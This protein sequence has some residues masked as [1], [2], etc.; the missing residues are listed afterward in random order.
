MNNPSLVGRIEEKKILENALQSSKPEMV[1][2]IGRR[3]IGKT[4]LVKSVYGDRIDYEITGIQHASRQEQLRNFMMQIAKYSLGHFPITQPKDWLEAFY[5]L[6]KFLEG[7][8]KAEKQIIFLDELPWLETP[9]S[10]FLKGLGWFW[11][12]WAVNQNIVVVI[13]GSAASWMI[14]KVVH[15]KGGLHNRITKRIYLQPFDLEETEHFFKTKN[16][17]FDRYQILQLYM[18]LGGVPHYLEEVEGGKSTAQNIDA[19]CFS[20]NGL[21]WDEFPKL[22][23]S[24]FDNSENH[25]K[26]IRALASKHKGL[27]RSEIVQTTALPEGGGFSTV[28]EELLHS[29][30]I[31]VYLPFGKKKKDSLYRLTDEFSLFYFQFMEH[32]LPGAANIWQQ[33]SKTQTYIS[34]A[35][36]AFENI[37]FKHIPQIKKALG[38]SGVYA[39][40]Y[41][42]LKKGNE[43]EEGIQLDLLI[44][45]NDHVINLCEIK[46]YA[47]EYT[48]DKAAAMKYRNRIAKFKE[49]SHTRKQV[50][51]T[52]I[53]TFGIKENPYSLG[54][55]DSA[56]TMDD[57]F[58]KR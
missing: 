3:R 40:V 18:A 47:A 49:T 9:K 11:N 12:S 30:F 14:K 27:T 57:L 34:W 15:D 4:F 26:V 48:I 1:A 20:Q 10:G 8:Q 13:C 44:D 35:G 22:Y 19:I 38:I 56:L 36:Y 16:L 24:L 31:S 42:Y 21:L 58:E 50:F 46:F 52:M 28:I 2:V 54:L 45:R 43:N 51:L 41:S 25:V 55:V 29:G 5:L 17:N 32:N 6:S 39:I 37:C 23:S 7:K 33:L 53:T